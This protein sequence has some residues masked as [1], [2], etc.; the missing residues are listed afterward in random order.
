VLTSGVALL[1]FSLAAACSGG[2]GG[3]GSGVHAPKPRV[4]SVS[5]LA[6]ATDVPVNASVS[7]TFSEVMD[8]STIDGTAFT[9]TFGQPAT[10]VPGTVIYAH[11]TARFW[12]TAH[13]ANN[14]TYTATVNRHALNPAGVAIKDRRSWR[15]TTGTTVEPGQPVD[16]GTAGNF[17]I[18]A[19]SG[20]ST[21]PTSAI[22]GNVGISPAAATFITGFALTLD[23]SNTFATSSQVTGNVYAADYA[24]PTPSNL[25]TS[26]LDMQTAFTDAASRAPDF[27]ELGAGD[28]GGLTLAPGVYKW[29]TSLMIPTDVTLTGSAT[30]I[31]IFQ[32]S[33]D[34]TMSSATNVVLTGGAVPENVFW[35]VAGLVDV[36]TTAH[37]DGIILTATAIT[38][39]TGASVNGRLLAQT[40]VNIDSSTVVQP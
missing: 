27:T 12:P 32:V 6:H 1:L 31:W 34:L 11:M 25:T 38:L 29:G 18:L 5:P 24:P 14:T 21:V 23:A 15:F 3:G 10:P 36:G 30:D 7:A 26:V 20:I 19:K 22:T 17:A 4:V 28:I 13:L 39:R 2:S 35:Q 40:A 33:Q 16:L 9:V 8:A 37:L